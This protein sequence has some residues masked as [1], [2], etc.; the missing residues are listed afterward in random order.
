[1]GFFISDACSFKALLLIGPR[2]TLLFQALV[3]PLAA[4]V[5]WIA[6][7]EVLTA[8]HWL[9]IFITGGGITWVVL[10]RQPATAV[11]QPP[12]NLPLGVLLAVVGAATQAVGMV[13]SRQGIGD[14]DAVAATFI[15]VLGALPGYVLL[16]SVVGR[17]PTV[18]AAVRQGRALAIILAGSVVGPFLGVAACMIALRNCPAGMVATI[19]STMPLL[20]LPF[21]IL[22]YRERVSLRAVGGAVLSVLGVAL[23]CWEG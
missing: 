20:V 13:L 21:A 16:F 6:F 9:A 2:L 3:P 1:M 23:M 5:S 17:W 4:L 19:L 18:W 22:L 7:G 11:P 12:L 8:R 14:Y 10:E 15:R